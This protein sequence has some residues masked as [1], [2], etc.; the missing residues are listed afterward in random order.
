MTR[1]ALIPF[2]ILANAC[3]SAEDVQDGQT[4]TDE[5]VQRDIEELAAETGRN[6]DAQRQITYDRIG[7]VFEGRIQ[8]A[9]C[10]MVAAMTGEWSP[11]SVLHTTMFDAGGEIT[12]KMAGKLQYSNRHAGTFGTKGHD[13]SKSMTVLT[14]GDFYQSHIEADVTIVGENWN[15]ETFHM[16]GLTDQHGQ[17]GEV[18]AAV[19]DCD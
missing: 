8:A 1:F 4:Y 5:A 13:K 17:S 2:A 9:G 10:E 7:D 3:A 11:N 6:T 12:A 18:W 16:I 14:E 15:P 19:V